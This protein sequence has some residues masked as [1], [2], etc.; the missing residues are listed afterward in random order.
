MRVIFKYITIIASI[1]LI[2][3]STN[4]NISKKEKFNIDNANYE[5]LL[6]KEY[7]KVII[8]NGGE[9][10]EIRFIFSDS[11]TLFFTTSNSATPLLNRFLSQKDYI[12]FIDEEVLQ[13]EFSENGKIF[14]LEKRNRL[15]KGYA[16]VPKKDKAKIDR[17]LST[18]QKK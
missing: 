10:S 5:I 16:N 15:F 7:Q 8:D 13:Y 11:A 6:P 14:F 18:L 4:S 17:V 1:V 12:K 9:S 2:A 3:C